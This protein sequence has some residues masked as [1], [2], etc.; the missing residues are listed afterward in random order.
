VTPVDNEASLAVDS[1]VPSVG[2]IPT[3]DDNILVELSGGQDTMPRQF[4]ELVE[5][6]FSKGLCKEVEEATE[7][8]T[9]VNEEA[10]EDETTGGLLL[11]ELGRL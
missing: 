6:V 3:T 11:P 1:A 8:G 10:I 7:A 9:V 4:R 2:E 5:A